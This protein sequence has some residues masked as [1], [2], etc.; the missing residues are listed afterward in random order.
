M[1]IKSFFE[2]FFKKKQYFYV[3]PCPHCGSKKTGYVL[4][5]FDTINVDIET[6]KIKRLLNGELVELH[7]F[8]SDEF[9]LFCDECGIEWHGQPEIKYL[10]MQ[11]IEEQK[12]LR[13]IDD[14]YIYQR[15]NTSKGRALMKAYIREKNREK[16]REQRLE[17]KMKNTKVKGNKENEK[18]TN[19]NVK[20][21][22]KK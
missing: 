16:K 20:V 9:T 8:I 4:N 19:A 15:N 11:E 18:N 13:G 7:N 17:K 10:T 6:E 1:S 14:E 2:T 22:I 12:M 5:N 3:P 21:K